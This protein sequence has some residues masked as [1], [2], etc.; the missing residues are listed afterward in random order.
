MIPFLFMFEKV[1]KSHEKYPKG[2]KTKSGD[3]L[4]RLLFK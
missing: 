1:Y 3:N 2:M 4:V